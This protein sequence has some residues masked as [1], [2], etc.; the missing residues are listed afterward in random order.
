MV[1]SAS[2]IEGRTPREIEDTYTLPTYRHLRLPVSLVRGKGSYVYDEEGNRYLDVYAGHAVCSIGHCHPRWVDEIQQQIGKLVF[3]SNAVYS[4]V[5]GEAAALL[6]E[7]SYPGMRAA[8]FCGSG[9]EAGETALKIAR[10]ATGRSDVVSMAGGFHGRTIGALSVSGFPALRD[11]FPQ[12]L[13]GWTRF[14]KMGDPAL[15]ELPDPERVAAVIVEPI[16]SVA[17]VYAADADYYRSLRDYC[18]RQG[19]CL[20][21]DEVQTGNG[22]TGKW[23]AG[24]HWG[25]EPDIV[26]TAKGVAGGF[27][28]GAV[29]VNEALAGTVEPG[30][31][32]TT[33]GGNPLAAAAIRATYSI[34]EEEGLI[35]QVV[36]CSAQVR[37]VLERVSGVSEVRGLGY[38]LGVECRLD[39]KELQ[40][41]LLQE[42]VL[43]GTCAEPHTIRLL[44]PLT[45]GADEWEAFLETFQRVLA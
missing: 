25:V 1:R 4:A 7:N 12:N 15:F 9:S 2:N 23:F 5:R 44:P 45:F 29:I 33:F 21:F 32:A 37:S 34:I 40:A 41:R 6:V 26:T 13:D 28:A 39:A 30:D 20:I 27:P 16:Q 42:R 24:S 35:D 19:I 17:G 3:Y 31:H 43:V 11:K 10:K 8:F 38:L 36:R 22:R 18:T 14:F